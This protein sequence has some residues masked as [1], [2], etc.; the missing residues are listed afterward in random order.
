MSNEVP[1]YAPSDVDLNSVPILL[2]QE[3]MQ[4]FQAVEQEN[5]QH[6]L[7]D[8]E[9]I[10]T[11]AATLDPDSISYME[12]PAPEFENATIWADVAVAST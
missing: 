6:Q 2:A 12:A 7:T 10:A 9:I 1:V 3:S 8:E 4:F 11:E 5:I